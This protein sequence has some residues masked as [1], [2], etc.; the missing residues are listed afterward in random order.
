[1]ATHGIT[2]LGVYVPQP[3]MDRRVIAEAHSWAFKALAGEAKGE[4]A[5]C[6]FDEDALTMAVEATRAAVGRT[7]RDRFD[8]LVLASVTLPFAEPSNSG[9][10]AATL[11]LSD[12]VAVTDATGSVRAGSSALLQALEAGDQATLVVA[13]DNLRSKPASVQEMRYGSAAVAIAVG[14]TDVIARYLGGVSITRPLVER[15]RLADR[16]FDYGWEERWIREEGYLKIMADA[17]KGMLQDKDIAND[18]VRYLLV[19]P[20]VAG[21]GA[22]M[23]KRIGL[24]DVQLIEEPQRAC[25]HAGTA[26]PF[27]QLAIALERATPGDVIVLANLSY[28]CDVLAFEVTDAVAA[29]QAVAP[30]TAALGRKR[31]ETAYLKYLAFTGGI[32]PDW[33]MRSEFDPKTSLTQAYR[34]SEQLTAFV[35]GKCTNCGT[36][37]FPVLA[38]CVSCASTAPPLPH[39]LADEPAKVATFTADWLSF[40]ISPPIHVGLMQFESGARV[41]MEVADVAPNDLLPVGASVRMVFRRKDEDKLRGYV[42]YFWKAAPAS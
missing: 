21:A 19:A 25:G 7:E 23:A 29:F 36:V 18:R 9:M 41:F 12:T 15:F 33:G 34:V 39:P 24:N 4:K 26:A 37:Q 28:G 10:L 5:F 38:A 35:A 17:V 3:R 13:S 27:L 20:G 22:A 1:M 32:E 11:A 16:D 8:R 42:R 30:A 31:L 6:D 2:A 14:D 40:T